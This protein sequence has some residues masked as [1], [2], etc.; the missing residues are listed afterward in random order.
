VSPAIARAQLQSRRLNHNA[1]YTAYRSCVEALSKASIDGNTPSPDLLQK[2][3]YEDAIAQNEHYR[4]W[5]D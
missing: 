2:E 1:A 3:L 4:S 5:L